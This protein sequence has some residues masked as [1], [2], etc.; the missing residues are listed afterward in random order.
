MQSRDHEPFRNV[1]FHYIISNSIFEW[2]KVKI[3]IMYTF[4]YTV[5]NLSG[6]AQSA[7]S[8]PSLG[9]IRA[10]L[11]QGF[12]W[13]PYGQTAPVHTRPYKFQLQVV[14][15]ELVLG[16]LQKIIFCYR[17]N[18]FRKQTFSISVTILILKKSTTST[19]R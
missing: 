16:Q 9:N 10:P 3:M 6:L 17:E 14:S 5:R 19:F 12:D 1:Y 2:N 18:F 11:A 7:R 15:G 4:M 13:G 8:Q